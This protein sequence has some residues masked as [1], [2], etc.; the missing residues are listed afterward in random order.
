MKNPL[1][2][3][4]S[5]DV[6]ILPLPAF[7]ANSNEIA[8]L[9]QM[10]T[11]MK[12]Q[13]EE[14]ITAL[15]IR[16]QR[17]E[18]RAQKAE[19]INQSV[20]AVQAE[21]VPQRR[22]DNLFNPAISMVV[23]GSATTYFRDPEAWSL[24]GFQL[25]GES[26][27]KPQGLSLTE[28]ELIISSNVDDWF[29]AQAT[30]GLHEDEGSTE[31]DVEEAFVDSLNLPAGLGLR[32]GRFFTETGYINTKHTHAWN[33]ADAP[34]TSQA[35]LGHQYRDDGIRLSWL[36]PTDIFLEL[37]MEALRGERFTAGGNGDQFLGDAQNYF[38]RVGHDIGLSH[39]FRLG[40]SYLQTD[41][42]NRKVGH[43]HAEHADETFSFSGDSDLTVADFVWKWAPNGDGGR[44]NFT[45]QTEYFHRDEDGAVTF[46][47]DTGRALLPY[48][49]TQEGFYAEGIYQFMPRW[50]IGLRYDRLWTDND[51]R[52]VDNSSG[53]T[54]DDVLDES[55]L[56]DGHDPYRWTFMTD[57]SHSEFSLFRL[58]FTKDRSR[59]KESD[60]QIQLQ[61][62]MTLGAHGAH[63][64]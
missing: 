19:S 47:N 25:G 44:Q 63:K 30:I 36:A 13:Y 26:G 21:T 9:K 60:E 40:L 53:E 31:I 62:I 5:A 15:E 34:L 58:Q 39:G 24:Q 20:A 6:L 56:T 28:T 1:L 2:H 50:R 55:G 57:Y 41:P 52:V 46:A 33:F 37:G 12:Q 32:F 4:V 51:L 14:R 8:E 61:Y 48:D 29:F 27:L 43:A 17:A 38:I 35:F 7:S 18:V 10:V 11:Q 3:A 54:D 64:Y 42:Q 45:F 23:Q 22:G 16:I 49:G 59:P